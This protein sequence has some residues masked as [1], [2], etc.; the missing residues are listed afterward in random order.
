LGLQPEQ[1]VQRQALLEPPAQ[2]VQQQPERLEL[3]EPLPLEQPELP[4]L[5]S[6][7]LEQPRQPEPEQQALPLLQPLALRP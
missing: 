7:L 2:Q 3:L 1:Q 4:G 5:R 6:E